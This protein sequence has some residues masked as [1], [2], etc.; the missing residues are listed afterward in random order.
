MYGYLVPS[1][2]IRGFENWIDPFEHNFSAQR[3]W[4]INL[5]KQPKHALLRLP[6]VIKHYNTV[7]CPC[8]DWLESVWVSMQWSSVIRITSSLKKIHFNSVKL[9]RGSL[10]SNIPLLIDYY[11]GGVKIHLYSPSIQCNCWSS[12]L[13]LQ[14][15]HLY[16][17]I[18][19]SMHNI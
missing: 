13:P 17:K 5:V 19:T 14:F 1:F 18:F 16:I 10:N 11:S 6:G 12:P 8:R 2:S 7:S 4:R 15:M 9:K 3:T